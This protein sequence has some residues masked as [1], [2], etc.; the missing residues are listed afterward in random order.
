MNDAR[1]SDANLRHPEFGVRCRNTEIAGGGDLKPAAQAPSRHA[2]N[3]GCW[4]VSHGLAEIAQAGDEF[5]GGLL[6]EARHLLD[7]G[8][9]DHA[10]RAFAGKDENADL[11]VSRQRIEA[12]AD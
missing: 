11:S 7:V 1:N 4:K 12:F 5:F 6:V 8:S 9:A 3:G 10:L 2:R